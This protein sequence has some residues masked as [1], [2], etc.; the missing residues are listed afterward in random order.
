VCVACGTLVSQADGASGPVGIGADAREFYGQE[1]WLSRQRD[2]LGLPDIE[3][4]ARLDLPERCLYWLRTLLAHKLPPSRALDVGSAHGAFVSLLRYAG[5]DALG[6]EV[7]PW[8]VDY[9]QRTFR[10]P[11]VTGTIEE[12]E[13]PSGSFDAIILN[14]VLEH[15][16]DPVSAMRA[17]VSLLKPDGLLLVQTPR[18]PDPAPYRD[19]ERSEHAFLKMLLEDEHIYLFSERSLRRFFLSLGWP[20]LIFNPPLFPYDMYAVVSRHPP[21]RTSAEEIAR[22]LSATPDA[23]MTLA[24]LDLDDRGRELN[25]RYAALAADRES[26]VESLLEHQA[27]LVERQDAIERMTRLLEQLSRDNEARLDV[28][29]R[30]QATMSEQQRIIGEISRSLEQVS[31]DSDARLQVLTQHQDTIAKQQG[32]IAELTRSLE[33]V[34]ADS[35]ARLQALTQHQDTVAKQQDIIAEVTRSLERVSADGE[36]RLQVILEQQATIAAQQ[37]TIAEQQ[38]ALARKVRR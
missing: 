34:S 9:A 19:L 12:Q 35:D 33:Q 36:A 13:L 3:A 27:Q 30:Q 16:G 25:D 21:A 5:F 38:A 10:I 6:L 28:V 24:L 22:A 37:A 18:Y 8:V 29:R 2:R 26:Q 32:I 20:S 23:R 7:S 11:M 15:L 1:Y 17:C 4:R 31:A 14:D